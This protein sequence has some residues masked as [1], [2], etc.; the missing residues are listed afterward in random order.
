MERFKRCGLTARSVSLGMGFEIKASAYFQFASLLLCACSTS[1]L[2]ASLALWTSTPWHLKLNENSFFFS[3][4]CLGHSVV[5]H[6]IRKQPVIILCLLL[7][8][9]RKSTYNRQV[10][11][12]P[13]YIPGRAQGS[14][15]PLRKEGRRLLP[16][17]GRGSRIV[18]HVGGCREGCLRHGVCWHTKAP[19]SFCIL[20]S[21]K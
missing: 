15:C 19:A 7:I 10:G 13:N 21:G 4:R 1:E 20:A 9:S 17:R 16:Q 6:S 14:T 2:S 5:Y 12:S 3:V 18:A 8:R 11:D